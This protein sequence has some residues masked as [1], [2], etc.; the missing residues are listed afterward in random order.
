M[1]DNFIITGYLPILCLSCNVKK[2]KTSAKLSEKKLAQSYNI[3]FV[4]CVKCRHPGLH[5]L[6]SQQINS[7]S[8]LGDLHERILNFSEMRF[9]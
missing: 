9:C 2:S 3:D 5:L 8:T 4:N 7:K 6:I 1:Q